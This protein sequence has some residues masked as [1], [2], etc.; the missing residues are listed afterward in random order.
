MADLKKA[1]IKNNGKKNGLLFFPYGL[2]TPG[3]IP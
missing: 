3:L 2:G 1:N